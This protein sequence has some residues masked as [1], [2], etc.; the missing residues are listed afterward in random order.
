MQFN[1]SQIFGIAKFYFLFGHRICS[2]IPVSSIWSQ[3][4]MEKAWVV[5]SHAVMSG[6]SGTCRRK[7]Q[8]CV[9]GAINCELLQSDRG[10]HAC[11]YL[12]LLP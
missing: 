6:V 11:V 5:S 4:N 9:C 3:I 1:L 2:V 8:C 10:S 7:H 12:L